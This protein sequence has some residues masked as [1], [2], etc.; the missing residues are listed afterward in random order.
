M[1]F[2]L[3]ENKGQPRLLYPEK[4]SFITEGEIKTFYDKQKLKE[5]MTIQQALQT[6]L[7]GILHAEEEDKH[8]HENTGKN[9]HH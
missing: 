7:E 3:K 2:K 9:K 4:L 5:F 6:V 1:Y 8:S